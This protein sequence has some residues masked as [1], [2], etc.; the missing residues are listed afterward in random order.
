MQRL[1]NWIL[2]TWITPASNFQGSICWI[3]LNSVTQKQIYDIYINI[4]WWIS[5]N[6][7]LSGRKLD[8]DF[9]VV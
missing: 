1:K 5:H 6:F 3:T 8:T 7:D 9:K 2:Q 4:S